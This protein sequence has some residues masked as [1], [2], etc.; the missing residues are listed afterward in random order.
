MPTVYVLTQLPVQDRYTAWYPE[1][2]KE[3]FSRL[4]V[5]YVLLPF[6]FPFVPNDLI[7]RR[8]TKYDWF[9]NVKEELEWKLKSLKFLC[10]YINRFQDGD[11]IFN[12]DID[13]PGLTTP[14]LQTLRAIN[15]KIG[16]KMTFAGIQHAGSYTAGDW[17]SPVV[18]SKQLSEHASLE[19]YDKIYV[20]SEY[21]R[22]VLLRLFG[23]EFED[24]IKNTGLPFW[25]K[26]Y[27]EQKD[28][29]SSTKVYDLFICSR[30][31]Q[32]NI[33]L[34]RQVVKEL[35]NKVKIVATQPWLPY[36]GS[37]NIKFVSPPTWYAYLVRL[38]ESKVVFLPK[39]DECF[40]YSVLEAL[41]LKTIPIMPWKFSYKDLDLSK[42][43]FYFDDYKAAKTIQDAIENYSKIIK[44]HPS[45]S[46]FKKFEKSGEVMINDMLGRN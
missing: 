3:I 30:P 16:R 21:H 46:W 37:F 24:K 18:L 23:E 8:E 11:V 4:N 20:G 7:Y 34:V 41:Y 9:T 39:F 15:K 17:Y 35:Q 22:Q 10:A 43:H 26:L 13:F 29:L 6:S 42:D 19:I 32:T 25:T 31:A 1:Y 45:K 28:F 38:S 40:G 33:T 27:D 14:F 5:D 12:L 36:L 44:Y 2:W